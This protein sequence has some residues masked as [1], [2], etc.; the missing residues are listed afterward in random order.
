MNFGIAKK[1]IYISL[2]LFAFNMFAAI[3]TYVPKAEHNTAYQLG[4]ILFPFW[5]AVMAGSLL[6]FLVL[7]FPTKE[8]FRPEIKYTR[9]KIVG[10]LIANLVFVLLYIYQLMVFYYTVPVNG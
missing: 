7:L 10:I 9:S 5:G 6:G 8:Q 2:A 3:K 1:Y 4:Y